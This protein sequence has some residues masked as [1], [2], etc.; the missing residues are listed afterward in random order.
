MIACDLARCALVLAMLGP[1]LPL[2]IMIA[3]LYAVTLLQPPFDA[4][5]SAVIRD[6]TGPG[7]YPLAAARCCSRPR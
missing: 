6:I 2:G 5:R 7:R 1:G 3:L 4:A